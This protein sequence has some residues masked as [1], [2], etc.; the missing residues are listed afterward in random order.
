MRRFLIATAVGLVASALYLFAFP[1]ATIFYECIVLLHIFAGAAFLIFALPWITRLMRGRSLWE[2][3][4]WSIL[5]LGGAFGAVIIFTGAR[6]NMWPVLYTH[7]L[8]S[9]AGCAILLFIWTGRLGWS[10]PL[11]G[12]AVRSSARLACCLAIATAATAG[13]WWV[14]TVP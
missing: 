7:E 9:A 5:L 3:L 4:G 14:R 2:K 6:R 12:S 11:R 10:A 8:V 13:A 1:S